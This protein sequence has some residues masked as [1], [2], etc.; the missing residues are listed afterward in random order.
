MNT[1][2]QTQVATVRFLAKADAYLA[3]RAAEKGFLSV[4]AYK[5]FLLARRAARRAAQASS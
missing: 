1:Q 3:R 2:T 5:T 4:E